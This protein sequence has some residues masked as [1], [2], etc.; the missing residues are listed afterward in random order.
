MLLSSV[1][2]CSA[3]Q[4]QGLDDVAFVSNEETLSD[5]SGRC[6]IEFSQQDFSIQ[7][8]DDSPNRI[9][10]HLYELANI[11]I[12]ATIAYGT[13]AALTST[14]EIAIKK[15]AIPEFS[16]CN[17]GGFGYYSDEGI[18]HNANIR[19]EVKS[20]KSC[21]IAATRDVVNLAVEGALEQMHNMGMN[22]G[23]IKF[24]HDSGDWIAWVDIVTGENA[25]TPTSSSQREYITS[26][27]W[28]VTPPVGE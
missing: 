3:E 7:A 20:G 19:F 9:V 14:T 8:Y 16:P 24:T 28:S 5:C 2:L 27:N 21:A 23:S 10:T 17:A 22:A 1:Q 25:E 18:F 26:W 4:L 12:G 11:G 6:A 15:G 13:V